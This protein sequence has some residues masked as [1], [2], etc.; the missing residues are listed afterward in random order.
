MNLRAV[1]PLAFALL[2]A[3]CE[4]APS[5]WAGVPYQNIQAWRS[6][7]ITP[8]AAKQYMNNGF[9]PIDAK[10]W[11]QMGFD[12]ALQAIQWHR[13]GFTPEQAR[14]WAAKGYTVDQAAEFRKKGLTVE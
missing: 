12:N 8:I 10:P 2:L 14:K 9:E 11:V 5:P 3:G 13:A 7:G 6:L 1:F 4:T